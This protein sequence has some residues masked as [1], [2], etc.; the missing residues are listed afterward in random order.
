MQGFMNIKSRK[1]FKQCAIFSAK[2][3]LRQL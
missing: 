1:R 3:Q 2:E